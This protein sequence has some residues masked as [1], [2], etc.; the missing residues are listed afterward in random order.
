MQQAGTGGGG[1]KLETGRQQLARTLETLGS[2]R[3][4]LIESTA[5]DAARARVAAGPARARRA[6]SRR[7]RRPTCRRCC[8]AAR[9]YI[10]ANKPGRTEIWICSDLR[11]NDWNAESGRWQALRDAFLEFPQGVRVPPPRLSRTPPPGTSRSG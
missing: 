4:V 5:N 9:D 8:E 6:P 10:Q 11:E 7:A 1:S 2:A 3:W